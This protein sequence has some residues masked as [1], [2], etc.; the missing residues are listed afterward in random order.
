MRP[1]IE[2]EEEQKVFQMVKDTY[3]HLSPTELI[4][5]LI[6]EHYDTLYPRGDRDNGYT[7]ETQARD[8]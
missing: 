7:K 8:Y 5:H 3:S 6:T 1:R 2:G 4:K